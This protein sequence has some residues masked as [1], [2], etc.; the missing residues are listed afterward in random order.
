MAE[1]EKKDEGKIIEMPPLS[2]QLVADA[3]AQNENK[4]SGLEDEIL[5]LVQSKDVKDLCAAMIL[6]SQLYSWA[7]HH[8][9]KIEASDD[10]L[11]SIINS[12]QQSQMLEDGSPRPFMAEDMLTHLDETVPSIRARVKKG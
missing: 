2:K 7:H 12:V 4:M 8:L 10:A 11:M 5:K 6:G 9:S 1:E 3:I